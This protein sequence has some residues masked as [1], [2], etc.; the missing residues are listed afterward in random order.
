MLDQYWCQEI[1]G[2]YGFRPRMELLPRKYWYSL[3]MF[4]RLG[5]YYC[6]SF[7]GP[8]GVT[9]VD[10]LSP[11]IFNMVVDAVIC[12]WVIVLSR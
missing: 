2:V 4:A 12:H 10:P 3:I 6:T 9:Q 5:R 11:T 1:L 8:R 7:T